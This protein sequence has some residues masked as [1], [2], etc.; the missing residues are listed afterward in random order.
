M[1]RSPFQIVPFTEEH[2][3]GAARLLARRQADDRARDPH[4]PVRY[5]DAS[6][7]RRLL[8]DLLLGPDRIGVAAL[9]N[10]AVAGYLVAVLTTPAPRTYDA[11][12]LPPRSARVAFPGHATDQTAAYDL[13]RAMYAAAAPMWLDRGYLWHYVSVAAVAAE[14]LAA[15]RS[16]GF[17]TESVHGA[18]DTAPARGLAVDAGLK[19]RRAGVD[20]LG[21]LAWF[22]AEL[23]RYHAEPPVFLPYLPEGLES[24]RGYHAEMLPRRDHVYWLALDEGRPAGMQMVILSGDEPSTQRPR[25]EIYISEAVTDPAMRGRGVGGAM[26]DH[27]LGWAHAN[28]YGR[29]AVSW[30]APNLLSDR[31]WRRAGFHPRTYRLCR[32]VDERILWARAMTEGSADAPGDR[33]LR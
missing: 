17:G 7:T 12:M 30:D 2:L 29:C 16:L 25:D 31:F 5:G 20:D 14:A 3:D 1:T 27:T 9:R 33:P 24:A 11:L 32:A 23:A 19:I 13:Y 18:R 26:V 15:W 8:A 21:T 4:L 6:A 22:S 10:G 28:G